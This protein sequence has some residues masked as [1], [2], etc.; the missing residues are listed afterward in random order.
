MNDAGWVGVALAIVAMVQGWLNGRTSRQMARDKM[1][2]D[3]A[4][5]RLENEVVLLKRD[6]DKCAEQHAETK[7]DLAE[8]KAESKKCAEMHEASRL[9]RDEMRVKLARLEAT[10]K[11]PE[12][13]VK[14]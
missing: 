2:H 12:A 7:A 13:E 1:D 14:S 5:M 6:L 10:V 9:D 8:S 11:A 4:V 3:Q